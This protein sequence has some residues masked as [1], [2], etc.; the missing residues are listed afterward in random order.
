MPTTKTKTK[1]AP[2]SAPSAIQQA[3]QAKTTPELLADLLAS[4]RRA[5]AGEPQTPFI[6]A[7]CA[8]LQQRCGR[9]IQ[10][11]RL[12]H[13][14]P[15]HK[16]LARVMTEG[17]FLALPADVART[18]LSPVLRQEMAARERDP[19][20]GHTVR[21]HEEVLADLGTRVFPGPGLPSGRA[22]AVLYE[23]DTLV[24]QLLA[25]LTAGEDVAAL[26]DE[27]TSA[28]A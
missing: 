13:D 12:E 6:A 1:T 18:A 17:G 2:V 4:A 8:V 14:D 25:A 21:S 24:G 3:C 5:L 15:S 19:Y 28:A 16:L 11:R 22:F 20:A 9:V 23:E 7:V 27:I 26:V 10:T